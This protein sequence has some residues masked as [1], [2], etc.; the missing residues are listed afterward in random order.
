MPPISIANTK[1]QSSA[2]PSPQEGRAYKPQQTQRPRLGREEPVDLDHMIP[3]AERREEE[4]AGDRVDGRPFNSGQAVDEIPLRCHDRI[5]VRVDGIGVDRS[6][7]IIARAR[8]AKII[9]RPAAPV[10][11]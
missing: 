4:V 6:L 10:K 7:L 3:P 8:P 2:L 9:Y 1:C 5:A 11:K